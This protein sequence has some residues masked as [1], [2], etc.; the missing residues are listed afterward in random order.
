[1]PATLMLLVNSN[2]VDFQDKTLKFF[3]SGYTLISANSFHHGVEL[4]M[5]KTRKYICLRL[6]PTSLMSSIILETLI[7][8]SWRMLES[9]HTIVGN[10]K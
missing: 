4:Q 10:H 2:A 9:V 7:G 8:S 3:D 1:M 6:F 5:K